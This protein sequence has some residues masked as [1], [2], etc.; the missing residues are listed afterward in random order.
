MLRNEI[1]KDK[2]LCNQVHKI[3]F[4]PISQD[5][6]FKSIVAVDDS[7]YHSRRRDLESYLLSVASVLSGKNLRYQSLLQLLT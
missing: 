1:T 3:P 6:G 2:E 7:I 5:V 4:L